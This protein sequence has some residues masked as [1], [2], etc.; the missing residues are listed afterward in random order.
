MHM[1]KLGRLAFV[2]LFLLLNACAPVTKLIS[3]TKP[4][5]TFSAITL[6]FREPVVNVS[7]ERKPSLYVFGRQGIK[8]YRKT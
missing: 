4:P 5:S 6:L 2:P 7:D 3:T 1:L 8:T